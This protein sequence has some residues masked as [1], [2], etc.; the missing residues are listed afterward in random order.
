MTQYCEGVATGTHDLPGE[1]RARRVPDRRR[2][3]RRVGRHLGGARRRSDRPRSSAPRPNAAAAHFG[4]TTAASNRNAQYVIL[5]PTGTHPDGFNTTGSQFCAWHD[6][7]GDTD[8]CRRRRR[9]SP[10]GPLAFTNMP[11]VTDMGVQLRRELRQQRPAVSTTA[12]RS[13]RVRVRRDGHRQ[14]R[15]AAGRTSPASRTA[16]SARGSPGSGRSQNITPARAAPGVDLVQRLPERRGGC[17]RQPATDSYSLLGRRA[18]RHAGPSGRGRADCACRRSLPRRRIA[19]PGIDD[20]S[21]CPHLQAIAEEGACGKAR[22]MPQNLRPT[23][24]R[25]LHDRCD[26]RRRR[27]DRLDARCRAAAARRAGRRARA[28]CR[29]DQGRALA[30]PARAQHRGDGPARAAR[31]VPRARHE[32]SAQRRPAGRHHQAAAAGLDTAHGYILGIP[33]PRHRSPPRR[34]R[35]RA[36][37]RD[38]ARCTR[39]SA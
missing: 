20:W 15:P 27:A 18:R 38:P 33:Q 10:Y 37:R 11:Y 24:E 26:R 13:S 6:Y 25:I 4:N 22:V 34:S 30:R 19:L 21:F 7:T 2:A 12:S 28:R 23:S 36:R 32:I 16:T 5:S 8:A 9:S 35:G 14:S 29:A 3:R 31:A 39:S 17:E 1:R